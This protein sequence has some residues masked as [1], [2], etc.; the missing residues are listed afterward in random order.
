MTASPSPMITVPWACIQQEEPDEPVR[1]LRRGPAGPQRERQQDRRQE[2]AHR[3]DDVGSEEEREER[4][5]RPPIVGRAAAP[6]AGARSASDGL[7]RDP[8]AFGGSADH[9]RGPRARTPRLTSASRSMKIPEASRTPPGRSSSR[10]SGASVD[11]D[12][13]RSGSRATTSNGPLPDRQGRPRAHEGGAR[14]GC[15]PRWPSSP[16]SRSG[17]CRRRAPRARRA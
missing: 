14:A 5:H 11:E 4:G 2:Q 13:M 10:S 12:A 3:Q 8:L 6:V 15:A 1:A 16:R 9:R 7:Q 17:R